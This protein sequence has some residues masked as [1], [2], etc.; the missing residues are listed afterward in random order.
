MTQ[1]LTR[2]DTI[3]YRGSGS[4]VY[5]NITNRCSCACAFCLREWTDGVYGEVLTLTHEPEPDEVTR[6]VEL[7][8]LEG[9]ADEV[10]FCGFGEPTMRLDVVLAV[11][12]WL[13][14][15]RIPARLDT[16]GHGQLLNPDVDV[17]AALAAAGLGAVTVSLNAADP[18][19]YDRICRPLFGKAYRAVI[20]F[21]EQCVQAR[22]PDDTDGRRLPRRRPRRVRGHRHGH[23]RRLSAPAVWLRRAGAIV[24]R[25]GGVMADNG[26]RILVVDDEEAILKLLR[27]PLEKEGYQVVTARDGEEAL[28]TFAR[29]SFDLVILDLMLPHVDGME[30]CRRIRAQSIVPII[31][32]TAKSDEFDKVLGLEIG[33]DDYITKDKFSLREFRSRVRAQLRRAEMSRSAEAAKKE[34]VK[35]DELEVDLLKRNVILRGAKIDLTYIEFEILKTL[36]SHPGRVYSRQLLLQLVWGDSDYRD[37]RTVDVHIRHLREK[38]ESDPKDPEFIF[39]VRN[40]GYKFR[41]F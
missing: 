22:H 18:E 19:S 11:T 33:A 40:I 3:A 39:T 4:A 8:F 41:E 16:N 38:L 15:R 13:R 9:P 1:P 36:I 6:A 32:L 34:V 23:G 35:V 5:L 30:V 10:V 27:F 25:R 21:A 24:P 2:T 12:E 14:L 28:E 7:E 26:A 20:Q 29:E 31:M 37:A 17:P